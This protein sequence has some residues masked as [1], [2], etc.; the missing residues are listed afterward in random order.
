MKDEVL[1]V[2][3]SSQVFICT[4]GCGVCEPISFDFVYSETRTR[5]GELIERLTHKAYQSHCCSEMVEIWDDDL[6]DTI[7]WPS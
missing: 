2:L 4:N 1:P 5:D 6:Q 3:S 7:D